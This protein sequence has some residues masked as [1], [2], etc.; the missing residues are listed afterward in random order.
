MTLM[1]II[2]WSQSY[3]A[4]RDCA[5]SAPIAIPTDANA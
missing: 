3:Y 1:Y 2:H 4:I 5:K